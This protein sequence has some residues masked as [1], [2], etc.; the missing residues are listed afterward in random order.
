M[1]NIR[2]EVSPELYDRL[3]MLQQERRAVEGVK[4]SLA[5]LIT[6]MVEDWFSGQVAK[7]FDSAPGRPA[8]NMVNG[9]HEPD[10]EGDDDSVGQEELMALNLEYKMMDLEED[11]Q[12]VEKQT[13]ELAAGQVQLL[14]REERIYRIEA[15]VNARQQHLYR[16]KDEWHDRQWEVMVRNERALNEARVQI[17]GL[18]SVNQQ[19]S[20]ENRKL[21]RLT[22]GILQ[23][24]EKNTTKTAWDEILKYLPT[25]AVVISGFVMHRTI[26]K[27]RESKLHADA[28]EKIIA[29][30]PEQDRKSLFDAIVSAV[31]ALSP[32]PVE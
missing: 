15:D 21:S 4:T 18:E 1:T 26:D 25:L 29:N 23:R 16:E 6:G 14:A 19:L 27:L 17:A 7:G 22:E 24:I 8:D 32:A 10:S 31:D 13:A 12:R 28:L 3:L 30:V 20:S 5:G 11:R 9:V 2:L